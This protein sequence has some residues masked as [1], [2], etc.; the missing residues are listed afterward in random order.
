MIRVPEY[1][2]LWGRGGGVTHEI[3]G[4]AC[5]L[6]KNGGKECFTVDES[7]CLD[8]LKSFFCGKNGSKHFLK[9]PR[10][11]LTA[12]HNMKNEMLIYSHFPLVLCFI[13]T[14]GI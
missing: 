14:E 13:I 12:G 6:Q 5:A 1:W 8:P 10:K 7:G 3:S 9:I 11:V 4:D 2:L